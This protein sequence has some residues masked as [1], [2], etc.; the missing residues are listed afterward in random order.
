MGRLCSVKRPQANASE[1]DEHEPCHEKPELGTS[2]GG[3]E[4]D[5]ADRQDRAELYGDGAVICRE[6]EV[7]HD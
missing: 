3:G 6:E 1:G 2:S 7:E 4:S 5:D